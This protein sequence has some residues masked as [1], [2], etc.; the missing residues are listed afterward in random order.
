MTSTDVFNYGKHRRDCICIDDIVEGI[1]R[2]LD[3][4]ATSNSQWD[5][6]VLGSG[7][8][9]VSWRIYNIG[10]NKPVELMNCI[11][12]LEAALGKEAEK[13]LLPLRSGD[14]PDTYT[15]SGI[16]ERCWLSA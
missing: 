12:A 4:V 13:N 11:G 1:I 2:T 6:R 14:V 16:G 3:K 10:N 8:S 9:R 5:M 7:T 15:D